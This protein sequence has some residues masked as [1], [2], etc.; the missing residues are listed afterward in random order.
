MNQV[1]QIK[2][3]SEV[4]KGFTSRSVFSQKYHVPYFWVTEAI[5]EGK[6]A[7]HCIDG[8]IY[9]NIEEALTVLMPRKTRTNDKKKMDLFS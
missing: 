6:I 4:L 2:E 8:K 9:I 1:A 3:L 5:A 7:S